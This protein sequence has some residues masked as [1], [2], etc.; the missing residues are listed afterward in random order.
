MH[1]GCATG[2]C[3]GG[4]KGSLS[5]EW[6]AR[7]RGRDIA[8]ACARSGDRDRAAVASRGAFY[9]GRGKAVDELVLLVGDE[10]VEDQVLVVVDAVLGLQFGMDDE[11]ERFVGIGYHFDCPGV[12]RGERE[13]NLRR[14]L[15]LSSTPAT[16]AALGIHDESRRAG[17]APKTPA[18][19]AR[20]GCGRQWLNSH[21]VGDLF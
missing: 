5:K 4:R 11:G 7:Q 8:H 18:Y 21:L 19:C 3:E 13:I 1:S 17:L 14:A 9:R 2:P 12:R 16:N 6:I 10:L 20:L 15:S